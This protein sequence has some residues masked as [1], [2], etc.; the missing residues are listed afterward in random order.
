MRISKSHDRP[1]DNHAGVDDA[2]G[3]GSGSKAT[4][5]DCRENPDLLSE[6]PAA[7]PS[8]PQLIMGEAIEHLQGRQREVYTLIMREGKSLAETGEIL[9]ITKSSAA[10]YLERAIKFIAQYC[11]V[12]IKRGRV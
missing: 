3:N 4:S 12:A 8:A 10:T 5:E 9:G 11:K 1:F 6:R 7:E 2:F